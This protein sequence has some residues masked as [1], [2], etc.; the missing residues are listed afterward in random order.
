[1]A[2]TADDLM[3]ST[4][5]EVMNSAKED[6]E[7][8]SLLSGFESESRDMLQTISLLEQDNNVLRDQLNEEA[9]GGGGS[10]EASGEELEDLL[11]LEMSPARSA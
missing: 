2:P 4:A 9:A 10:G 11:A 3:N 1:M 5:D 7:V 6:K 8:A